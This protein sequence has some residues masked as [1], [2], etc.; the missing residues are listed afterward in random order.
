MTVGAGD[1]VVP[2]ARIEPTPTTDAEAYQALFLIL[3]QVDD[4]DDHGDSAHDV[5]F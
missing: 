4:F 3:E 2:F 1:R 5:D